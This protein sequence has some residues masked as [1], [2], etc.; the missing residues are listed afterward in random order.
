MIKPGF[1]IRCSCLRGM[2]AS[3]ARSLLLG[4]ELSG[5]VG[6]GDWAG[7]ML[8]YEHMH[9]HA[10]TQIYSDIRPVI[11]QN[12]SQHMY[13]WLQ[14]HL[15][16]LVPLLMSLTCA[17]PCVPCGPQ[18][19]ALFNVHLES[20]SFRCAMDLNE[21]PT[22]PTSPGRDSWMRGAACSCIGTLAR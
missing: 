13:V 22:L 6:Q 10:Y 18:I 14:K 12:L 4:T 17:H 21:L 2:N 19:G 20:G 15:L 9:T 1:R 16:V 11:H 5:V 3:G 7:S 8:L